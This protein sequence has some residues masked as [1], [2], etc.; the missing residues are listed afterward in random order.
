MVTTTEMSIPVVHLRDDHQNYPSPIQAETEK[1]LRPCAV[2]LSRTTRA[3]PVALS[4]SEARNE[5]PS[6]SSTRTSKATKSQ[7]KA[8]PGSLPA[9]VPAFCR[10]CGK[11]F[12]DL[13]KLRAHELYHANAGRHPCKVCGKAF[14]LKGNLRNHERTHTGERPYKC[15]FC[16]QMFSQV[17]NCRRHELKNHPS[18]T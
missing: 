7:N 9:T 10:Y 15:R 6:K 14:P 3:L 5:H 8:S 16:G 12:M 2:S 17:A 1:L 13:F 18:R 4:P 11:K